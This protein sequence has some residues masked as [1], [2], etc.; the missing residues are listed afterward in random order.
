MTNSSS[1]I[2]T[3]SHRLMTSH[4]LLFDLIVINLQANF[5]TRYIFLPELA[6]VLI[7][8]S[9]GCHLL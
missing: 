6:S 7:T 9:F 4:E 2:V 5:K 8:R 3:S 1:Q